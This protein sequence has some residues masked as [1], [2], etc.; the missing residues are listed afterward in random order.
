[1]G[2]F[3]DLTGGIGSVIGG[4]SS[5]MKDNPIVGGLLSTVVTGYAL[6]K[7]QDSIASSAAQQTKTVVATDL[8]VQINIPPSQDNKV[9]VLYGRAFVTGAVTDAIMSA[10]RQVMT[11]VITICEQTGGGISNPSG[12]STF[13]FNGIY[14][15]GC[16]VTFQ[17]DGVT[18]ASVT[19]NSGNVDD[20]INGLVKIWTFTPTNES[21]AQAIVPNWNSNF[22]MDNLIFAVAQ[23]TYNKTKNVTGIPTM[24]FDLSNSLTQPGD[25]IF[26]YMTNTRYGAGIDSGDIAV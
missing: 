19:D 12:T 3:D 2:W 5:F 9:P 26:D 24:T 20:N 13:T 21:T 14:W 16:K 11:Y 25:C 6:N 8:G 17:G 4:V 22:T 7:V 10:N 15:N 1:M 23:V 18:A